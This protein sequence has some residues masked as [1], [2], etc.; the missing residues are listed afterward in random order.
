MAQYLA[1]S[2]ITTNIPGAYP[3][4]NVISNPVGVTASGI[5]VIFGE[6]D[7]GQSY[8][9]ESLAN[10]FFTPN[11][12]NAVKQK[13]LSGQIVDAFQA[14]SA[15]SSDPAITG[16]ANRIYIAKTNQGSKA[17]AVLAASNSVPAAYGTLS[18]SNWGLPGNNYQYQVTSIA[19]ED[20][21]AI[22]GGTIPTLGS[23]LNNASFS[24]RL[25]GGAV[26]VIA[27]SATSTNHDTI[28]HLVAELNALFAA[29]PLAL[30]ASAG[31]APSSIEISV[32]SD[33]YANGRGWGKALEL[34]DSTPG[35]LAALGLAAGL[36]VSSQE[37]GVQ[38]EVSNSA[39]NISQSID[40]TS[41]VQ[42]Q[43]GYA[44]TTATMSISAT[45]LTTTVTGG[46]GANLNI[47]LSQFKTCADLA[48]Y[49][50]SQT[51]YSAVCAPSAQQLSPSALDEVSAIGIAASGA[52]LTPGRVKNAASAF[53]IAANNSALSFATGVDGNQGL[54]ATMAN[55][56]YL[57]GGARGNT[58][59]SDIVNVLAQLASIQCNMVV[60]LFSQD[61]SKDITAGLTASGSTY[62][63]AAINAATKNHVI[64]YSTPQLKHNRI[65]LCS[66]LDTYGNAA[67][68]AQSLGH[69]RVSL[70]MQGVTQV[71]ASTGL[72]QLF[73][74]WYA[75]VIAAGMQ[76]GGFYQ[77]IVNKAAN[78]ISYT[79]PANFNSGDPGDVSAALN[80][81]LLFMAQDTGRAGYWVSD[82][83]TYGYDTNFVYN[84]IQAVYDS[85]LIAL[86]LAQ[87]F[88]LAFVGK[89]DAD[90]DS[91]V[92]LAYLA[93]KMAQYKS[94]KLIAA[95][96]DAPLGYKNQRVQLAA[97][98]MTVNV[99]IKLATAIYFIPINLNIS[100][101]Q[102]AAS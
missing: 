42:L 86:D 99:E 48:A 95:S 63:I 17:S 81:G 43:V 28:P 74:P 11:Q 29:A 1:T 94:Q 54:P 71:S 50:A 20:A 40:V 18:D 91:S 45:A 80:A 14:L 9:N 30:T 10:N 97:P 37:P 77:A 60:P 27:L 34:V 15:P 87:S 36:T 83:T 49:I 6:A 47:L 72:N 85:D 66:I 55:P 57:S 26:S 4:I 73:Q 35:D 32:S 62:T 61:A 16:S 84:S 102:N 12:L 19:A 44:G 7:G 88:F 100:A 78:I 64:E 69:Y 8:Q 38:L 58:L 76:A 56:A 21:P 67:E 46:S 31:A 24:V 25:N 65:A 51:G 2:Q 79:D 3:F 59:A 68:Q 22:S 13:Y 96:A 98:T 89:S 75:A 101:V 70:T 5:I 39:T 82:Q 23:A 53:S 93:Q 52:G 41:I 90:V 33:A 92:G